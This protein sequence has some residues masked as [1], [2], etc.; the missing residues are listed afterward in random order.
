[1][2]GRM[3]LLAIVYWLT[4]CHRVLGFHNHVLLVSDRTRDYPDH[5]LDVDKTQDR[6]RNVDRFLSFT[7]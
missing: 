2:F 1:M 6:G 4:V 7:Y 3:I 5:M